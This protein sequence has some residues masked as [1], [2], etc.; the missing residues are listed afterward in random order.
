MSDGVLQQHEIDSWLEAVQMGRN[1]DCDPM[2]REIHEIKLSMYEERA[3]LAAL[4]RLFD[5]MLQHVELAQHESFRAA[6]PSSFA[7]WVRRTLTDPL[8]PSDLIGI[9]RQPAFQLIDRRLHALLL[10]WIILLTAPAAQVLLAENL[11]EILSNYYGAIA[12]ALAVQWRMSD[13]RKR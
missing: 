3:D 11:Q 4:Q 2:P 13:K 12:L 9:R 5:E 8:L 7:G 6:T 10:M 1:M